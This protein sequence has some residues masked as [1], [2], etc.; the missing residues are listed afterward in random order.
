MKPGEVNNS[1]TGSAQFKAGVEFFPS[2]YQSVFFSP[3][4]CS[5]V[6]G[7]ACIKIRMVQKAQAEQQT[8]PYRRGQRVSSQLCVPDVAA[9]YGGCKLE[10]KVQ[11]SRQQLRKQEKVA[12]LQAS[13]GTCTWAMCS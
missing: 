3:T 9:E 7:A 4:T 12:R 5:R 10:E 1:L 2:I 13:I 8:S 11:E 6:V